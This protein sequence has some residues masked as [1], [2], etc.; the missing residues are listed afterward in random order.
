M[1]SEFTFREDI[2][3]AVK[4]PGK[5]RTFST[6][7]HFVSVSLVDTRQFFLLFCNPNKHFVRFYLC[8]PSSQSSRTCARTWCCLSMWFSLHQHYIPRFERLLARVHKS[9]FKNTLM[10]GKLNDEPFQLGTI[11][12]FA[13][14]SSNICPWCKITCFIRSLSLQN[15]SVALIFTDAQLQNQMISLSER[16]STIIWRDSFLIYSRIS[17]VG[18]MLNIFEATLQ[19]MRMNPP[20]SLFWNVLF[21][22][23]ASVCFGR[24]DVGLSYVS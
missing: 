23:V 11:S 19:V 13:A 8:L 20:V 6:L 12:E 7:W 21:P 10:S 22:A 5:K 9:C 3:L 15:S 18:S 17:H 16:S 1:N 4:F 24:H 14:F 2:F